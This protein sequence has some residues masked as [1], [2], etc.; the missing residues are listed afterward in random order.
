MKFLLAM[1][2]SV[3]VA[4]ASVPQHSSTPS[5]SECR[6]MV[7]KRI[8]GE[9]KG[10]ITVVDFKK[11]LDAQAENGGKKIYGM[12]FEGSIRFNSDCYWRPDHGFQVYKSGRP[13]ADDSRLGQKTKALSGERKKVVGQLRFVKERSGWEGK[14][15]YIK[16]QLNPNTVPASND[17]GPLLRAD[18]ISNL[19][20]LAAKAQNYYRHSKAAGGG[21]GSFAG[22]TLSDADTRMGDDFYQI[23]NG[24]PSVGN[25]DPASARAASNPQTVIIVGWGSAIGKDGIHKIEAYVTVTT[26]NYSPV[27][28]LN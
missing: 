7:Q 5:L 13:T 6:S 20:N 27:T 11:V 15:D 24:I 16:V 17:Q 26:S 2:F 12:Q 19:N 10:V 14:I 25:Y 21:G 3:L 23:A 18:L 8:Q 9:S 22:F 4:A 28:I 1:L